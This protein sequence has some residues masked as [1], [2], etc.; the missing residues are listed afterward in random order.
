MIGCFRKQPIIAFYF[1]PE[2]VPRGQEEVLSSPKSS[3]LSLLD[4]QFQCYFTW[5]SQSNI[6]KNKRT[7]LLLLNV[8]IIISTKS[9][10][11]FNY[12]LQN[13]GLHARKPL[14]SPH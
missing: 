8:E 13:M 10:T 7:Y 6:E 12:G 11:N 4:Q 1:E 5:K 9:E 14:I 2:T 3:Y